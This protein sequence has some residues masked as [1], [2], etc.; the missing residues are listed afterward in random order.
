MR[1]I[2]RHLLAAS[3]F[4]V[5]RGAAATTYY[6]SSASGSDANDGLSEASPWQTL[7]KVNASSST[8]V[9]GD[10][11]LFKRGEIFRGSMSPSKSGAAGKPI[12]Y[13]GYGVGAR[14]VLSGFT[15]VGAWVSQ[16]GN[17]YVAD[18][19]GGPASLASV[20]IGGMLQPIGRFPKETAPN[21][22]FLMYEA[23]SGNTSFTDNELTAAP[24]FTGAEVVIRQALYLLERGVVTSHA[25]KT[26]AY[27][28]LAGSAP[29]PLLAGFGYFFQNHPAT[30]TEDGD[31]AYDGS[32]HQIRM[33]HAGQPPLVQ[34]PTVDEIIK[35]SGKSY[36]VFDGLALEGSNTKALSAADGASLTVTGCEFRFS[37]TYAIYVTGTSDVTITDNTISDSLSSAISLRG[38]A[39]KNYVV[40]GNQI[41]RTGAIA[42]MG[43]SGGGSYQAVQLTVGSGGVIE[44]NSIRNTGYNAITFTGNDLSI[45]RNLID[46]FCFVKEDGGGI[47]TWNGTI[48]IKNFSNRVIEE[49]VIL[50]GVGV[51]YGK[52][53]NGRNATAIYLDYNSNNISITNNSISDM[54]NKGIS[55]TNPQ[56][57]SVTGNTIFDTATALGV[58]RFVDDGSN[59]AVSGE[60]TH[61]VEIQGNVIYPKTASQRTF[62][63]IDTGV[64]YPAP[65]TILARLGGFGVFDNNREALPNP[66][67][68]SLYYRVDSATP[69]VFPP[70]FP[71]AQWQA[72]TGHDAGTVLIPT[73]PNHT[74]SGLLSADLVANGTFD[75]TVTA[76]GFS[77]T[78]NHKLEWDGTGKVTGAGSMKISATSPVDKDFTTVH[79][80]IGPVTQGKSYVLRFRTVGTTEVGVVQAGLRQT[81]SPYA[82]LNP[83]EVRSF[84][85]AKMDHEVL[86]QPLASEAAAS[87]VVSVRQSSGTVYVDDVEVFEADAAVVTPDDVLRFE[88][89]ATDADKVVPLD[90]TY[91]DAFDG[92]HCASLTLA[93]YSSHVLRRSELPCSGQ[94][95]AG[96]A[97]GSGGGSSGVGGG[98]AGGAAGS[99]GASA[100]TGGGAGALGGAGAGAGAAGGAGGGSAGAAGVTGGAGAGGAAAGGAGGASGV[101]GAAGAGGGG[102][103]G[104][105]AGAAGVAGAAGAAGGAGGA[106]GKGADGGSGGG[107]G[108]G[109]AGSSGAGAKA[110]AAG[111]GGGAA[112]S[113]AGAS[114]TDGAE[115]ADESGGCGCRVASPSGDG[116]AVAAMLAAG[117]IARRRRQGGRS[118]GARR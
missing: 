29:F 77:A 95:G 100:G 69:Y 93:P 83:L 44:S 91:L 112:G 64:N 58:N 21:G 99:A 114:G 47:Y 85:T 96:G 98:L 20:V 92:L 70:A 68:F 78:N 63:Y 75:T 113:D 37:G 57:V 14:P 73:A 79:S 15:D 84:G 105:S 111:A 53:G 110:G 116:L 11:V 38:S 52:T 10:Q 19:P 90:A 102:G 7:T 28:P 42:G 24:N 13:G 27:T 65:S 55:A 88:Y 5:A 9:P 74:V 106:G 34:V 89:N 60:T 43:E 30:L 33:F 54:G 1:R 45:K 26:V 36:L 4:L 86:I 17:T 101:A 18:V 31:W 97:A 61:D 8:L 104:G 56:F 22:G 49:N 59:P 66:L 108:G 94:G 41:D 80:P 82:V 3:V 39:A 25:G 16:G 67:G 12:T 103:S 35:V 32:K 81:K 40:T 23:S 115:P 2:S 118:A 72:W 50:H 46:T 109:A 107:P 87:W 117:L 51:E 71:Y 6:V 48:P 76:L 62:E